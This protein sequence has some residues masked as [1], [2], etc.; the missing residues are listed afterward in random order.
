MLHLII[1]STRLINGSNLSTQLPTRST[2]LSTS[3][4]YLS[5][6]TPRSTICWS[7]CNWSVI[8]S[9]SMLYPSINSFQKKWTNLIKLVFTV[10]MFE[11]LKNGIV[12]QANFS[13][14]NKKCNLFK[15]QEKRITLYH[16][17]YIELFFS[18]AWKNAFLIYVC[19]VSSNK[20]QIWN[21]RHP[22]MSTIPK[23][24]VFIR[25]LT[26]I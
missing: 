6:G 18:S 1:C 26:R 13:V 25:N 21:K 16:W 8:M 23:N 7:F 14:A 10:T 3:N 9:K 2:C 19:I 5:T 22:L 24:V 17:I 4:I 20:R 12:V 15:S 11:T